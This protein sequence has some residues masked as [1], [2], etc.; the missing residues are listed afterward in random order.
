MNN[1]MNTLTVQELKSLRDSHDDHFL[2]DVRQPDEWEQA[3]IPGATL[4]PLGEL[5]ERFSEL[6]RNQKLIIHCKAGGRSARACAF[7]LEQ[8]FTNVWNVEGGMDA[9]QQ[10]R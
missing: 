8:G 3:N 7:L 5:P 10:M 1:S 2:L 9:W 4:I 6:P